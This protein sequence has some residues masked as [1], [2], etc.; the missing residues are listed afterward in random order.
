MET[1]TIIYKDINWLK[2]DFKIT[3]VFSLP[4]NFRLEM[5]ILTKQEVDEYNKKLQILST[6]NGFKMAK[7]GLG[8]FLLAYVILSLGGIELLKWANQFLLV[9]VFAVSGALIG[10]IINLLINFYK[11]TRVIKEIE[12]KIVAR[13]PKKQRKTQ[14]V[15]YAMG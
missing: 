2:N 8:I 13:R 7:I 3:N 12:R 4:D 11:L 10:K 6:A 1:E 15:S 9:L 5:A 14:G